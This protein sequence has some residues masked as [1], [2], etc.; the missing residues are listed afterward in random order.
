MSCPSASSDS[1][2]RDKCNL[3]L[4]AGHR[5]IKFGDYKFNA[6]SLGFSVKIVRY[7]IVFVLGQVIID[8]SLAIL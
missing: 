2:R 1:I 5:R 4:E 8:G 7:E 3:V 6:H